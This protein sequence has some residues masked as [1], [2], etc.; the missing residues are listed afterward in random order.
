MKSIASSTHYTVGII[1][2]RHSVVQGRYRDTKNKILSY[3]KIF[4]EPCTQ[5]APR[6]EVLRFLTPPPSAP[7]ILPSSSANAI[8]VRYPAPSVVPTVVFLESEK[9]LPMTGILRRRIQPLGF[10]GREVVD[11]SGGR[12]SRGEGFGIRIPY[13]EAEHRSQLQNGGCSGMECE[14]T[15][16]PDGLA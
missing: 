16:E 7:R 15:G 3:Q 10:S 12:K 8:L 6:F 9:A 13:L 4:A 1:K 2:A 11:D 5:R 14:R